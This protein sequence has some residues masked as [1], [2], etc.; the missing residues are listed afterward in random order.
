MM[1]K[2]NL[3]MFTSEVNIHADVCTMVSKNSGFLFSIPFVI[4]ASRKVKFSKV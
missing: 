3:V 2:G 1:L 4:T